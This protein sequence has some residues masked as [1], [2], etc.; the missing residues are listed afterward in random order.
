MLNNC[1]MKY[2]L[3]LPLLVLGS[4]LP[5]VETPC[6]SGVPSSAWT[7]LNQTQL[8]QDIDAIDLYLADQGLT[9]TAIEDPSGLRYIITQAGTGS[10]PACLEAAVTVKYTGNL[11]SDPNGTPFDSSSN[12][13][14]FYL[15]QLI[16]GWQ[17]GIIKL[18]K[19]TK[20]TLYIPSGLAYGSNTVGGIPANSNLIFDIELIDFK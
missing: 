2:T 5:D 10:P 7:S 14:S 1:A 15:N 12:P 3:L 8:Q 6:T 17:I 11:L 18:N 4:C 9:A 20:A 16:T 19:G 13:V